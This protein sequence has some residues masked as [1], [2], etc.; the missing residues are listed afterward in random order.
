MKTETNELKYNFNNSMGGDGDSTTAT[1]L[2][3]NFFVL[4]YRWMI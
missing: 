1:T 2:P 3:S 4:N